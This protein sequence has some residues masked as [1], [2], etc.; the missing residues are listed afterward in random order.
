[1]DIKR[2]PEK[3]GDLPIDFSNPKRTLISGLFQETAKVGGQPRKFLTYIPEDLDYCQ[4][5]LVAAIP[6]GEKP[7]EYLETSGL[8]AFAED[9]KLF[10]HLATP[11]TAWNADGSDADYLNAIYVAIQARDFYITMQDNIYLCG[12]GDGSFGCT[13]DGKR[14]ERTDDVRRPER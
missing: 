5:C 1:M 6:S 2:F 12:I 11:E 8:K 7:E 9:K 10:L 14:V 13:P 3:M 4:P